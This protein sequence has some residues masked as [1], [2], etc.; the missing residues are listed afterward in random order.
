[1]A[2]A[3]VEIETEIKNMMQQGSLGG[4]AVWRLPLAQGAILETRDRGW[5]PSDKV[6]QTFTNLT[7]VHQLLCAGAFHKKKSYSMIV[8]RL[9]KPS[10]VEGNSKRTEN[11]PRNYPTW[12]E[13]EY[14]SERL[15]NVLK[16]IYEDGD[17][18]MK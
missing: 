13:K 1:M 16:K 18:D 2:S 9:L 7:G 6:I 3:L 11:T 8:N 14:P 10:S 5:D 17:D 4:A 15:M 12:V